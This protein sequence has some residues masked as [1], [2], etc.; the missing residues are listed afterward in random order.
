MKTKL[1]LV[2]TLAAALFTTTANANSFDDIADVKVSAVNKTLKVAVSKTLAEVVEVSIESVTGEIVHSDRFENTT[3]SKRYDLRQLPIGS[4]N[5]VVTKNRAKMTQP[6]AINFDGIS[7]AQA[8]R[9]I[10]LLPKVVLKGSK[11]DVSVFAS[12]NEKVEVK[13]YDTLGTSV[14]QDNVASKAFAKRYDLSKLPKGAY[15]VEINAGAEPEY[16]TIEL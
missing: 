15:I 14:F 5:L 13:I 8:D 12:E 4:Y 9:K 2:L 1:F 10:A 11:I 3:T 7:V 6:F 16:F